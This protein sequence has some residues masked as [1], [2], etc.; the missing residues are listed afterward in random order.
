MGFK[1]SWDVGTVAQ[2]IHAV[3]RECSS[4]YNDG[5]VAFYAKQDLYQMKWLI[6]DS[7]RQCPKFAGEEEW[8]KEQ[9]QKKIIR[10]LKDE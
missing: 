10:I 6:E 5:F 9:E 3:V 7:L 8:L 2:H 1:K 4:T